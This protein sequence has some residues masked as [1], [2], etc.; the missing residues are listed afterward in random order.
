MANVIVKHCLPRRATHARLPRRM[1]GLDVGLTHL[2]AVQLAFSRDHEIH[3]EAAGWATLSPDADLPEVS[4]GVRQ[5][6]RGA[7]LSRQAVC[8]S[9]ES[10]GLVVKHFRHEHLDEAELASALGIEAEET[11]QLPRA[12]FYLDWH[13]NTEGARH[14]PID[15]VLVASPKNELERH[16]LLLALAGIV[17][18]VVD[19]GCFAV[20]NLYHYLKGAP[21]G[22]QAVLLVSLS[23]YRA[24]IAILSGDHR[25]FPRSILAPKE[26]WDA[27]G[28]YLAESVFDTI[29]RFQSVLKGPPVERMVLTGDVPHPERLLARLQDLAPKLSFWDPVAD[30]PSINARLRPHLNRTLGARLAT[31][32]GLALR[33]DT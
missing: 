15:G 24:D 32:L 31:S 22:D 29:M 3:L 19:V 4:E 27:A 12:Q 21:S 25:I 7:G 18:A 20:C 14:E 13:S 11:L 1:V 9:F 8:S 23:P 26:S 2:A 28:V 16:L 10:A 5:L 33:R 30:L 17:P 6:F